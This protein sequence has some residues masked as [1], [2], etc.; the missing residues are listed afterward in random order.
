MADR[1]PAAAR[2]ALLREDFGSF[3]HR[4]FQ[5]LN[6]R[7]AAFS[8]ATYLRAITHRLDIVRREGGG[9]LIIN[10]PPRYLKSVTIS[11]AWVAWMLGQDPA[12][13]FVCVSYSMDLAGKHARDCRSVMQ[14]DWY[15]ALFPRTRLDKVSENDL[16]TTAKGGRL[17]TSIGGTLTGRGG[18]YIIIDDP[19]KPEEAMSA[20]A[21]E[22][23]NEWFSSTLYSRLN[24]KVTGSIIIV[25]Q[26]LHEMDLSGFLLANDPGWDVLKLPAIA[27]DDMEVPLDHGAVWRR[28]PGGVLDNDREDR[29]TLDRHKAVLGSSAFAAQYQQDP[30]PAEGNLVK[31]EWLRAYDQLPQKRGGGI[32]VQSWDCASKTGLMNDHSVCITALHQG[33]HVYIIDVLRERLTFPELRTAAMARPKVFD[34]DYVLIEEASSGQ[35]LIQEMRLAS[36]KGLCIRPIAI[37]VQNEKLTRMAQACAQ[38]EPGGLLLPGESPWRADFLKEV[39]AFPGGAHDDQVDA[40]SQLINWC[41][42]RR[43]AAT[44]VGPTVF[45]LH[46]TYGP[47]ALSPAPTAAPARQWWEQEGDHFDDPDYPMAGL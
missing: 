41:R 30:I 2:D 38:I 45:T 16:E 14:S 17:S 19:I 24:N 6:G 1:L 31:A 37:P 46:G 34:A 18:D 13:N 36:E 21:R 27:E 35:S 25:M 43:T 22:A 10:V 40:L 7:D 12:L 15:R 33:G 44:P 11:V 4:V 5:H 42:K 47:Q 26:R 9:R 3:L 29:A 28:R 32:I 23:V 20:S 8:D 39:L